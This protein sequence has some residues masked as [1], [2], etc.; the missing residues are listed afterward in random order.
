MNYNEGP[1][2]QGSKRSNYKQKYMYMYTP[3]CE[4]KQTDVM[5]VSSNYTKFYSFYRICFSKTQRQDYTVTMVNLA[6]VL[7][8]QIRIYR[9]IK[10]A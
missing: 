5:Q 3:N 7:I 1:R 2:D 6:P 10:N 9:H 8:W 4:Q